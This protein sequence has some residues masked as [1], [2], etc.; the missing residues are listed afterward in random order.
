MPNSIRNVSV[1]KPEKPTPDF[2]LFPHATKRWAKKVKGKLH[3]FG[4][5]DDPNGALEEWVRV[6][7]ALLAGLPRPQHRPDVYAVA[8]IC[9]AFLQHR[10][11]KVESGELRQRTWDE[12]KAVCDLMMQA[13]G[14]ERFADEI[15][16]EEFSKLRSLIAKKKRPKTI[17]NLITRCQAV[18][19]FSNKNGLTEKPILTG[20]Y[21][22]KPSAKE[23][24]IDK[25][26]QSH[27]DELMLE[28]QVIRAVLEKAST[29]LKAM[30]L[31]AVNTG[32]GNEDCGRLEFRHVDLETG[33]LDFPRPK[34]GV[35]RRAKLWPETVQ[36]LKSAIKSRPKPSTKVNR[37]LVFVT[38]R[39]LPW[40]KEGRANP[41]SREFRNL[42]DETGNHVEG[43]GF[44]SL[45]RTFETIASETNDQPAIDLSMGHE[46]REMSDLYR[47]R[48]GDK[49]LESVAEHVRRWLFPAS[50]KSRKRGAK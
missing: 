4:P 32:M 41:I 13:F 26:A 28:S 15:K 42:L 5:W 21:F 7:S 6:R 33:W 38:R 50:P 47:Q 18:I 31:L 34:T 44:Y 36:A 1:S 40:A 17:H 29:Q 24:R 2:P 30:I 27:Q 46:G 16:P 48:I 37:E 9:E 20:T 14:K 35:K 39:G 10:N 11:T 3:Y 49:R 22:E 25:A 12:Y 23:L 19:N 45:R 43:L 8:D